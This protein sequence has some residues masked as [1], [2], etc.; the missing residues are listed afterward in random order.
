MK[1]VNRGVAAFAASLFLIAAPMF[2][3]NP[4]P[5][6][7]ENKVRH[8][9][10]MMPYLNLFDDISFR[11]DGNAVTLFG[12]VRQ[13]WMKSDA[14]NVVKHIEGVARVDN[15]INVLPLSSMDDRI[16]CAG[17]SRDIQRP[18]VPL[19]AGRAAIDPHHRR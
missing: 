8:E 7:L 6:T 5:D 12:D 4:T 1:H 10:V 3:K 17:V 13:P 9:L 16:P 2:A 19:F 11:V 14:G 15:E 18:V